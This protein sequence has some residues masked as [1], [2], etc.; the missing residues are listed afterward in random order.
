M[1][2]VEKPSDIKGETRFPQE[3]DELF[4]SLIDISLLVHLGN[5]DSDPGTTVEPEQVT[6]NALKRVG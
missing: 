5:S 3:S 1:F 2:V 4:R 6:L